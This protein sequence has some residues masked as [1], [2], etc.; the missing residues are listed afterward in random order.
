M[1]MALDE[2]RSNLYYLCAHIVVWIACIIACIVAEMR[3]YDPRVLPQSTAKE[4]E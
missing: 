2:S 3:E 1:A 4:G